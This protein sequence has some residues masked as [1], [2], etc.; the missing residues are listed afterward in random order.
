M[1]TDIK[2]YENLANAIVVQAMQ[3]YRLALR[4]IRKRS[5][6]LMA[7]RTKVE[8]EQFFHS[9]WYRLLTTVDGDYLI[10]KVSDVVNDRRRIRRKEIDKRG[11]H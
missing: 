9:G 11:K 3:D 5:N 10:E 2:N 4:A 7:I 8:I 1:E 6:N